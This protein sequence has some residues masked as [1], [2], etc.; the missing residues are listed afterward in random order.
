MRTWP[1]DVKAEPL[2]AQ[3]EP[4]I[5]A[6]ELVLK[7]IAEHDPQTL[8]DVEHVLAKKQAFHSQIDHTSVLDLA[9]MRW[10]NNVGAKQRLGSL[11]LD[12]EVAGA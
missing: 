1:L 3:L 7:H 12:R 8:L 9:Y 4:F 6:R 10:V 2:K 5:A 11:V